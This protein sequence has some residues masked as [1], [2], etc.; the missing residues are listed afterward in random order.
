MED[1]K[2]ESIFICGRCGKEDRKNIEKVI[3]GEYANMLCWSCRAEFEDSINDI[4][5]RYLGHSQR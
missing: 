1:G 3:C 2:I 5:R 4:A